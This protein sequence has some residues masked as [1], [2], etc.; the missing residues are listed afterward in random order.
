MVTDEVGLETARTGGSRYRNAAVQA[1][2]GVVQGQ[3][4]GQGQIG[5]ELE[6]LPSYSAID[7]QIMPSEE[8]RGGRHRAFE[9]GTGQMSSR[10]LT[11]INGD[12]N[13]VDAES[14]RDQSTDQSTSG[15]SDVESL[16]EETGNDAASEPM[17]PDLARADDLFSQRI[18]TLI[19]IPLILITGSLLAI[20]LAGH[21]YMAIQSVKSGNNNTRTVGFAFLAVFVTVITTLLIV[22]MSVLRRAARRDLDLWESFRMENGRFLIGWAVQFSV[23]LIILYGDMNIGVMRGRLAGVNSARIPLYWPYLLFSKLPL[24]CF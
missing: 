4:Q 3:Y 9:C 22:A 19:V 15:L 1:G 13:G 17:L 24:F 18:I 5:M 6:Y 11:Y 23:C 7:A 14:S 10:P 16:S 20:F 8:V 2:D 12:Q 21:I